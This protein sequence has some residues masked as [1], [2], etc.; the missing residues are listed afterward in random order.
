MAVF[1]QAELVSARFG[2]TILRQLQ[3]DGPDR[4]IVD[5]PNV[6]DA[7]ENTYRRQQLRWRKQSWT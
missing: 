5:R 7:G 6:Q 2:P 1:L 4:R 3:A